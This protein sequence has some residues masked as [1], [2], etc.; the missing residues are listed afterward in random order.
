MEGK[1]ELNINKLINYIFKN[2][3]TMT[4]VSQ[5]YKYHKW[6]VIWCLS[7]GRC[8]QSVR[9]VSLSYS[10]RHTMLVILIKESSVCNRVIA[11]SR[12]IT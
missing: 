12:I 9:C 5:C 3:N 10:I 2:G 4:S 6:N 8:S 1:Y 7:L 11:H